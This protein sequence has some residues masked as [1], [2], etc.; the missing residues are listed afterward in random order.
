MVKFVLFL[1]KIYVLFL[2]IILELLSLRYYASGTDYTSARLLSFSNRWTGSI[3][4]SI[5]NAGHY[6]TLGAE[7]RALSAEVAG[8]R[9]RLAQY[10]DNA[11]ATPLP[12]GIIPTY[13]YLP[14][15]V[16]GNTTTRQQ[17][18]LTVDRGLRDD[19]EADMAVISPGG[20]IVG[21]VLACSDKFASCIS[22]LNVNFRTSGKFKNAPWVGS[23]WWD[24]HNSSF[25]NLSDISREAVLVKGDTVVTSHYS[26]IFPPDMLIGT[27]EDWKTNDQ[28]Y[29]YDV[30]LKLLAPVSSLRE[31]TLVRYTDSVER[32]ELEHSTGY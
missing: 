13:Q 15:R 12:E 5:R 22:V 8:L 3:H 21:Y 18:F 24:G 29:S 28:T 23:V 26:S 7:N 9:N 27:I 20:A 30:R 25:V 16:I 10:E 4:E 1:K 17:N 2:F 19:V 31:V 14:A 32:S 11:A 6:F